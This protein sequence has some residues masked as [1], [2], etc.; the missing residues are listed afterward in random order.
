MGQ[1]RHWGVRDVVWKTSHQQKLE[2]DAS[3]NDK[4]SLPI[5]P[6]ETGGCLQR[7]DP[8]GFGGFKV[9]HELDQPYLPCLAFE[10]DTAAKTCGD[11]RY[12]SELTV[13]YCMGH[14][15][16]GS[17]QI[18]LADLFIPNRTRPRRPIPGYSLQPGGLDQGSQLH[19]H[20]TRVRYNLYYIE[21][22]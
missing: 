15:N 22:I 7:G 20:D 16:T 5:S 8:H 11:V 17:S 18:P 14:A 2:H 21:R 13:M 1:Q 6:P 3:G 19:L 9:S 10:R 4:S 12:V